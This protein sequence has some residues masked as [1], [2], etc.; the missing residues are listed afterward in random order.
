[1][2]LSFWQLA[3]PLPSRY[4]LRFLSVVTEA[5]H[6]SICLFNLELLELKCVHIM[7]YRILTQRV[8]NAMSLASFQ[9][10]PT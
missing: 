2:M 8:P 6:I 1:M 9:N 5:L 10:Y 7:A 3:S 4:S